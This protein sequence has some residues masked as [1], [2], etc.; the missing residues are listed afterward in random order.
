MRILITNDD[1]MQ[2][3]GM[4]R[5][6]EVLR[7]IGELVIVAPDR[8]RSGSSHSVTQFQPLR[9]DAT[10][11]LD[12]LPAYLTNGT[13]A[14]C[15]SLGASELSE[16]GFDLVVSGINCGWNLGVHARYSGTVMAAAEAALLCLPAMAVSVGGQ[17]ASRFDTAAWFAKYV[18]GKVF[19]CGLPRGTFLNINVPSLPRNEIRGVAVTS[20]SDWISCDRFEK[21]S[22]PYGG[23]Y[24]WRGGPN[25]IQFTSDGEVA[26]NASPGTDTYAVFQGF[27][28][29]TP[30]RLDFTDAPSLETLR[31]WNLGVDT[32]FHEQALPWAPAPSRDVD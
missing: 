18:A 5:L 4:R 29:V 3:E 14:D 28:S 2:A 10:T 17:E 15:V 25:P 23:T 26:H 13:P 20:L 11:I 1:G 7:E 19:Q 32:G 12:G 8:Q 24:Y 16:G 27:I 31:S 22:D 21:R 30:L 6:C 9:V